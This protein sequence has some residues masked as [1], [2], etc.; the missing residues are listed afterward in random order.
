MT[1][2]A[3]TYKINKLVDH[4]YKHVNAFSHQKARIKTQKA[5]EQRNHSNCML[6]IEDLWT[7]QSQVNLCSSNN[8]S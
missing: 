6:N 5:K 2:N 1:K 7:Y 4:Y 3:V 8:P